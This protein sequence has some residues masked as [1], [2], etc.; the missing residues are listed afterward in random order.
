MVVSQ[1]VRNLFNDAV[2]LHKS[3]LTMMENGDLQD[4]AEKA[5]GTGVGSNRYIAGTV[6]AS[7]SRIGFLGGR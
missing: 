6:A 7:D 4:A 2:K 3:A 5:W 1:D